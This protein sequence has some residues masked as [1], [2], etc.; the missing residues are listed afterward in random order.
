MTLTKR[1]QCQYALLEIKHCHMSDVV[2]SQYLLGV[3]HC[4][5]KFL[6]SKV[7]QV[8]ININSK[9]INKKSKNL[10]QY[11]YVPVLLLLSSLNIFGCIKIMEADTI[12]LNSYF[13]LFMHV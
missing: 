1:K 11:M 4:V 6:F 9:V 13:R 2:L 3:K 8:L 10:L 12:G 5:E 7:V